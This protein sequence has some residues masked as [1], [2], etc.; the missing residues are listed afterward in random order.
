MYTKVHDWIDTHAGTRPNAIA[1]SDS[2]SGREY[3]YAQ[4]NERVAKCA[5]FMRDDLNIQQGQ[6]VAILSQNSSDFLEVC[7][8]NRTVSTETSWLA[9]C[10]NNT[11]MSLCE[12]LCERSVL[13]ALYYTHRG[14]EGSQPL[15]ATAMPLQLANSLSTVPW[16]WRGR[17]GRRGQRTTIPTSRCF[18]SFSVITLPRRFAKCKLVNV[19]VYRNVRCI[20]CNP[21]VKI[22]I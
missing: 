12:F 17:S 5:G 4:M 13:H 14:N 21:D 15:R 10:N 22:H 16:R 19:T 2:F 20:L 6:H 3:T 7:F 1:I 8:L 18:L 9:S 11:Q